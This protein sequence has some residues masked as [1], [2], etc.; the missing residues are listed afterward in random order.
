[1][2]LK[3]DLQGWHDNWEL[4][5][6]S[7]SPAWQQAPEISN[8]I[9]AFS[10]QNLALR[11]K[12]YLKLLPRK[13]FLMSFCWSFLL[14]IPACLMAILH[15]AKLCELLESYWTPGRSLLLV[16]SRSCCC[17]CQWSG[18]WVPWDFSKGVVKLGEKQRRMV[19][20][21]K[22]SP[23]PHMLPICDISVC[24]REIHRDR[25]N[26]SNINK[27]AP[28]SWLIVMARNRS[29]LLQEPWVCML[30]GFPA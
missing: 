15:S 10:M 9:S 12:V 17:F 22:Q 24:H 14:P 2:P 1:M 21:Q 5:F 11:H 20:V 28:S 7:F 13:R 16:L 8:Q 3:R 30:D 26:I 18:E 29:Q 19:L 25:L 23:L 27:A 6:S 4:G